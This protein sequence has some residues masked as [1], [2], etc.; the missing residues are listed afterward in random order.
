MTYIL[1]EKFQSLLE[2]HI[3]IFKHCYG[4]FLYLQKKLEKVFFFL[5]F[6]KKRKRWNERK[7]DTLPEEKRENVNIYSE[8]EKREMYERL[9]EVDPLMATILH[10]NAIRKIQRSLEVFEKTGK[11]HSEIIL[12]RKSKDNQLRF[13][14]L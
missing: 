14:F 4:N 11:K 8:E 13:Y 1:K 9:Q 12:E 7:I 3:I 2:E 5:F 10:P 6:Q